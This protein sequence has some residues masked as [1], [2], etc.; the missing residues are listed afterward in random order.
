MWLIHTRKI[1][2][3]TRL[4]AMV[5]EYCQTYTDHDKGEVVTYDPYSLYVSE[6]GFTDRTNR[7]GLESDLRIVNEIVQSV[8]E[9]V[10]VSVKL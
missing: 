8:K 3:I 10:F 5:V 9:S 4:K 6:N 7:T 2:R 1:C